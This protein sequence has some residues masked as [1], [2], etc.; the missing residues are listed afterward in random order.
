[1]TTG[2]KRVLEQLFPPQHYAARVRYRPPQA[3]YRRLNHLV[4]VP[5]TTWGLAPRDAVTLEVR[6]RTSGRT[7]R[8]PVLLT[9]HRG[10]TYLV[11]LAGESQW[12]RNVRAASGEA[13]LRQRGARRV[14]LREVPVHERADV[15]AAYV[16]AARRRSGPDVAD[17]ATRDYFGLEHPTLSQ[18]D[19]V[20]ERYPV[21][22]VLDHHEVA[23]HVFQ[24]GPWGRTQ[25]NA[26]AVRTETGWVLVDTG[27]SS[28]ATRIRAAARGLFGDV[29]AGAILLTHAHPDHSGAAA[30]LARG[31]GCPVHLHPA[32]LPIATGDLSAMRRVAA[33]LD[34]WVVL[35]LLRVVGRRRRD[36]ILATG[37]L[38]GLARVLKPGGPVPGL[39]DWECV[40]T[41]GHTP[42]HVSYFRPADGVLV[43][44]DALVT[45]RLNSLFGLLGGRPGLSGPPWYT[46]WDR[47][48]AR[49]S[50]ERLADL[51]PAVLASG[52]GMPLAGPGIARR[53]RAFARSGSTAANLPSAGRGGA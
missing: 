12:V 50:I 24:L 2:V 4:G 5:L 38:T 46:T 16:A 14:R 28:D 6:G 22:Q 21:L 37:S 47:A 10:A 33:P 19:A 25:T 27:W 30:E 51:E 8:T 34:R 42:G 52:H 15:L 48:V 45:M 11:S 40:P 26:Y 17:R 43:S 13:V 32:E 36:R 31:W 49:A 20:A 29:P 35:P 39:P 41:P 44:G 9:E 53:V 7:R 1:M 3:W 18:L 23:P